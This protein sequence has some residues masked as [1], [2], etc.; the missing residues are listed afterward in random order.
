MQK[1]ISLACATPVLFA[2]CSQTA[3]VSKAPGTPSGKYEGYWSDESGMA[4]FQVNKQDGAY[5]ILNSMGS[6][7][8]TVDNS[9]KV[10]GKT[11]TGMPFVLSV[12]GDSAVY[13]VMDLDMPY[14]R[15]DSTRYAELLKKAQP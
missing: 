3:T 4:L 1:I 10:V 8:G 9:G 6:L 11:E 5:V 13:S 12:V 14:V 15:I 2:A 7:Q